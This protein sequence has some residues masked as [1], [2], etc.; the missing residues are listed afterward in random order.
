MISNQNYD[1]LYQN[2][3]HWDEKCYTCDSFNYK[4]IYDIKNLI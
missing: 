4:T 2:L 1:I 3:K